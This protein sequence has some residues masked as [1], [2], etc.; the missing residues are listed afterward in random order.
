VFGYRLFEIA[1]VLGKNVDDTQYPALREALID[2]Y[3]ELQ[4]LDISALDLFMAIRAAT[5]VGWSAARRTEP[6][7]DVRADRLISAARVAVT[8]WLN[9]I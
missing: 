9:S 7:G 4:S 5:Y 2:G 3:R 8:H 6:G 1:T